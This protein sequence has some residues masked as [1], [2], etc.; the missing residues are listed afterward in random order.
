[1]FISLSNSLLVLT[2]NIWF[3][4]VGPNI[5]LKIFLSK[6]NNFLIMAFLIPMFLRHKSLLVLLQFYV[7]LVSTAWWPICFWK[8]LGLHWTQYFT[9]KIMRKFFIL[10]EIISQQIINLRVI[11]WSEQ[12]TSSEDLEDIR[13]MWENNKT[14]LTEVRRQNVILIHPL[15]DKL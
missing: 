5:L 9:L 15:Q 7:I 12:M 3:Y 10:H 4:F 6:T 14:D 8:T 11:F 1:M 13:W 2:L